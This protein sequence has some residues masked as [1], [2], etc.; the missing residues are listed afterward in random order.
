MTAAQV[1]TNAAAT[2]WLAER[3]HMWGIDNTHQRA[4]WLIHEL[5][6][7][8]LQPLEPPIPLRPTTPASTKAGR[9]RAREL[10]EQ[11]RREKAEKET[12][13]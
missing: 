1:A 5:H 2:R 6:A 7:Q 11:T 12:A 8:G 3:L 10:Y 13:R 9:K 4:E